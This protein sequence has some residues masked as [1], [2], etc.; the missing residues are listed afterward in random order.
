[1]VLFLSACSAE[2]TPVPSAEPK[3]VSSAEASASYPVV[4]SE[5]QATLRSAYPE[6]AWEESKTDVGGAAPSDDGGCLL[7]LPTLRSDSSLWAEAGGW[8]AIMDVVNPVLEEHD[9]A[10]VSSEDSIDGGWTGI[11]SSDDHDAEIR[12]VDKNFTE[13]T[14]TVPVSDGDCS[15][16]E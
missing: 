3:P 16:N 9:F 1:L 11:S 10:T 14:L 8:Q 7:I 13:I 15:A 12:F 2:P 6:V 4:L 5:M